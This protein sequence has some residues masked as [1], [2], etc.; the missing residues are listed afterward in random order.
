MS[1][2]LLHSQE[3]VIKHKS[4][5]KDFWSTT[6]PVHCTLTVPVHCTLHEADYT[7]EIEVLSPWYEDVPARGTLKGTSSRDTLYL[8]AV[9]VVLA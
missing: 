3:S 1:N 5:G 4:R 7:T 8:R 6:V 2:M 9:Q